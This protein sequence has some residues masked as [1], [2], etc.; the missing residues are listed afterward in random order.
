MEIEINTAGDIGA[1]SMP[2]ARRSGLEQADAAGSIGVSENF[3]GKVENGAEGVH[4]GQL[5]Q[6]LEGLGVHVVVD[7]PEDAGVLFSSEKMK[8]YA[9]VE[10]AEK[11][12]RTREQEDES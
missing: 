11:R 10:R 6:V 7:I 1:V 3:L 8:Q 4:W 2:H 9:H 12:R 5:F